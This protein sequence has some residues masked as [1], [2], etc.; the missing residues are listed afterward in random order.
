MMNAATDRTRPYRSQLRERQAAET[1]H[2]VIQAAVAL[3]SRQGYPATTFPQIAQQAGVSVETAQKHGP[4]A[5]LLRHAVELAAFGVESESDLFATDVGK[6]LLATTSVAEFATVIGDVIFG[7]N[8]P[9]AGLWMTVVGA[10]QGDEELRA[11]QTEMLASVRVQVEQVLRMADQRGWVRGDV[12]FDDLVEAV[13][14]LTSV[15]TYVRF[16]QLDGKSVGAYKSFVARA[17]RDTV[18]AT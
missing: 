9:S 5:A 18:L 7:I 2:R 14:V 12:P 13:C 4:K 17:L 8:A 1:R 3:F 10:S 15:D 6:A 16:V 11:F